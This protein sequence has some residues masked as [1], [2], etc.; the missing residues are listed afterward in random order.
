MDGKLHDYETTAPQEH[1]PGAV[2][3]WG[4]VAADGRLGYVDDEVKHGKTRSESRLKDLDKLHRN[5]FRNI[6]DIPWNCWRV[7]EPSLVFF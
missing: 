5:L 6:D 4:L 3:S 1:R 2:Y 7:G